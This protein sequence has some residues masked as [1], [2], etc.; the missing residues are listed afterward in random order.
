[1]AQAATRV[2]LLMLFK[3]LEKTERPTYAPQFEPTLSPSETPTSTSVDRFVPTAQNQSGLGFWK[4]RIKPPGMAL[5][6]PN[7]IH[8][9]SSDARMHL[10]SIGTAPA[11]FRVDFTRNLKISIEFQYLAC[12][13]GLTVDLA[14]DWEFSEI[15][16]ISQNC[17]A[18][19]ERTHRLWIG[20]N[21]F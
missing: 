9:T 16:T 19:T 2:N 11:D 13:S 14:P 17:T 18:K 3:P 8:M 4:S 15:F 10:G 20:N 5:D 7:R 12:I 21:C 6:H 1:M